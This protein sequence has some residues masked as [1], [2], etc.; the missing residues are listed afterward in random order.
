MKQQQT[1]PFRFFPRGGEAFILELTKATVGHLHI[2]ERQKYADLLLEVRCT[3]AKDTKQKFLWSFP[4]RTSH[5]WSCKPNRSLESG[6]YLS[7]KVSCSRKSIAESID[8]A[9]SKLSPAKP[10]EVFHH[11]WRE[12]WHLHEL[13]SLQNCCE[14]ILLAGESSVMGKQCSQMCG[15]GKGGAQCRLTCDFPVKSG[16]WICLIKFGDTFADV[17]W[18]I[19]LCSG[20]FWKHNF[21]VGLYVWCVCVCERESVFACVCM[22]ACIF[23]CVRFQSTCMLGFMRHASAGSASLT[24]NVKLVAWCWNME[25]PCD[26]KC[27]LLYYL[28]H[29]KSET[30]L[31]AGVPKKDPKHTSMIWIFVAWEK[32]K[33][34]KKEHD[35]DWKWCT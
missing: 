35:L 13:W 16:S 7:K 18:E 10:W 31:T 15:I 20:F 32:N 17:V 22:H 3:C 33:K 23:W 25:W 27:S 24:S 19:V 4:K 5:P 12:R 28:L 2:R 34:E 8:N 14:M 11:H 9:R 30:E 26:N 6:H 21:G 1:Q 29:E